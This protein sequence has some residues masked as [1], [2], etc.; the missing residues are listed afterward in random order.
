[1]PRHSQLTI[2]Q[3]SYV[4]PYAALIPMNGML[5]ITCYATFTLK[6]R[7]RKWSLSVLTHSMNLRGT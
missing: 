2:N 5:L 4:N 1:V 6:M 7:Q 3:T